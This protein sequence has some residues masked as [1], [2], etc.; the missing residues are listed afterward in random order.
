ME[1]TQST[2]LVRSEKFINPLIPFAIPLPRLLMYGTNE[3][4]RASP[5]AKVLRAFVNRFS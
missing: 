5:R 3:E 4:F 1:N 2:C